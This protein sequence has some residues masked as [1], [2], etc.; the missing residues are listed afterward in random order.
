MDI[1]AKPFNTVNRRFAVGD[2]ISPEDLGDEVRY[3]ELR[4]KRFFVG[5]ETKA[6]AKAVEKA[7]QAEPEAPHAA[8]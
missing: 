2:P 6:A 5:E 8:A 1:V 4:Q 3:G 7:A